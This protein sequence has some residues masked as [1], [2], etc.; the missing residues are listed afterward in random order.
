VTRRYEIPGRAAI[1]LDELLLDV[2]GTLT[3]Q[4]K[5]INGVAERLR[6]IGRDLEITLLSSDT[7]G[8]LD[9]IGASLGVVTARVDRGEEKRALVEQRGADR[10]AAIGNG[11]NDAEM[12]AGVALGIAVVGPEG[13]SAKTIQAADLVCGSINTALDLLLDEKS[14]ASTLRP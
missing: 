6:S 10:C 7:L 3:R 9:T 5:L 1:E 14:L 13:A 11:A 2:N 12:L 8:T 4:G